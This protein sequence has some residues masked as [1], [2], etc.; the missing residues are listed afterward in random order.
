MNRDLASLAAALLPLVL[1]ALAA[2]AAWAGRLVSRYVR[3][4]RY[5][6]AV[7]LVALGAA[8]VVADLFQHVVADLKDPS[9]A[10]TWNA[11][12][13]ASVKLRAVARLREL[14]PHAVA[15]ITGV[16]AD[17]AK[18][19]AL[20]GTFVEKGVVEM[21]GLATS[22][23]ALKELVVNVDGRATVVPG[24]LAAAVNEATA[25][26]RAGVPTAVLGALVLAL[27]AG[28]GSSSAAGGLTALQAARTTAIV[29]WPS[30]HRGAEELGVCSDLA[31][32]WVTGGVQPCAGPTSGGSSPS[33]SPTAPP[34]APA[35]P[36][37]TTS[38]PSPS[39][40]ASGDPRKAGAL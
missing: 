8:G 24:E 2:F 15:V 27:G 5:A 26:G 9:K 6:L 12:A 35:A 28:C 32:C 23:A 3:D 21:K 40:S 38:P 18:V 30:I 34:V 37:P 25:A 17:P 33:Q 7:E 14:Y 10:G 1:L 11:V 36:P 4:R 16:L 19:D 39:Q 20:F 31:P 29:T 22:G 13:A